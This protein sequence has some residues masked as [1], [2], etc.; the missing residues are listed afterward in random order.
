MNKFIETIKP[1]IHPWL[2]LPLTFLVAIPTG[3]YLLPVCFF[4]S[5]PQEIL[6]LI[7]KPAITATLT[8][9]SLSLSLCYLLLFKEFIEK[10]NIKE[11]E[12]INPPGCYKHKRSGLYFCQPCLLKDKIESPLY[13]IN[14]Y[15]MH[16]K[17]CGEPYKIKL[18]RISAIPSLEKEFDKA[19]EEW[20]N[21]NANKRVNQTAGKVA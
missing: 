3:M 11:Y 8:L 12:F 21:N 19:W 10:P 7:L 20:N 2:L 6:K 4:D 14:E 17:C 16:C 18:T 15:G 1:Y 9:I 13:W 5:I